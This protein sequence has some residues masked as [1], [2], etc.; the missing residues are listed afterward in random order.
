M[1]NG[2]FGAPAGAIAASNQNIDENT[3][4]INLAIGGVALQKAKL[5]LSAQEKMMSMLSKGFGAAGRNASGNSADGTADMMDTLAQYAASAGLPQEAKQYAS[6]ASTIRRNQAYIST[7]ALNKQIKESDLFAN[8]LDGVHDQQTW[9]Q[10]NALFTVQTGRQTPFARLPYSPQ[11]VQRLKEGAISAKDKATIAAAKMREK[12]GQEQIKEDEERIALM[13]SQKKLAEQRR[14]QIIKVGGGK[15][16]PAA[17]VKLIT[18]YMVRDFGKQVPMETMR[19][20]AGPVAER[21]Q[22]L[23]RTSP[24]LKPAEAA[25]RAYQ[26]AK[27]EGDFGG[28]RSIRQQQGTKENPISLP[29]D[30]AK[31]QANMYYKLPNGEIAWFNGKDFIAGDETGGL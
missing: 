23:L 27:A 29:E 22:E 26:E 31:W 24:G 20:L 2:M 7:Q 5:D 3:A 25:E 6:T 10:A 16:P 18:D 13:K 30:K 28:L 21:M 19:T 8:L 4:N 1:P 12:V 17:N 9:Q 11:L 14:E 15:L